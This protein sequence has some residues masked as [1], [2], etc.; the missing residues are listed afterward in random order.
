[1]DQRKPPHYDLQTMLLFDQ[2]KARINYKSKLWRESLQCKG[3]IL[4][5]TKL[6]IWSVNSVTKGKE[7]K[8]Q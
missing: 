4:S 5:R 6:N 7:V 3:F 1:M 2:T 8:N